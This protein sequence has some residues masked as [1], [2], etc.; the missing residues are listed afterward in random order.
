MNSSLTFRGTFPVTVLFAFKALSSSKQPLGMSMTVSSQEHLDKLLSQW[1]H[2]GWA[3]TEITSEGGTYSIHL[4]GQ[5]SGS[6][7]RS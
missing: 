7:K 1:Q 5:T 6:R 4:S 3:V 2:S